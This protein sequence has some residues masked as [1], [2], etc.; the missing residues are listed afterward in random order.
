MTDRFAVVHTSTG[1]SATTQNISSSRIRGENVQWAILIIHGTTTSG[2]IVDHGRISVVFIASQDGVKANAMNVCSA[3]RARH[4]FTS[5]SNLNFGSNATGLIPSTTASASVGR[6]IFDSRITDGIRVEWTEA[7][8]ADYLM[9]VVMGGGHSN[10]F[11]GIDTATTTNTANTDLGFTPDVLFDRVILGTFGN[12]L[13][14][15]NDV[16]PTLGFC[17]ISGLIQSSIYGEWNSPGTPT[18]AD[19]VVSNSFAGGGVAGGLDR[20]WVVTGTNANGYTRQATGANQNYAY[21]AIKLTDSSIAKAIAVED[22]PAGTGATAFT[23]IGIAAEVAVYVANLMTA[24]DTVTDGATAASFAI[25]AF[26][27]DGAAG[28]ATMSLLEGVALGGGTNTT[29]KS[30]GI[31]A[32][33]VLL[34]DAG[35]VASQATLQEIN[36][37]GFVWNFSSATAGRMVILALGSHDARVPVR[38]RVRRARLRRPKLRRPLPF[39][40]GVP[41]SPL[42]FPRWLKP[43]LRMRAQIRARLR[44]KPRRVD[45]VEPLIGAEVIEPLGRV[46]SP[47]LIRGRVSGPGVREPEFDQ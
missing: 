9:T 42:V 3:Q 32:A 35:T 19:A 37:N 12:P 29:A 5:S 1:T 30:D 24:E 25:G 13:T 14:A 38:R 26:G 16:N 43:V 27:R 44:W 36:P 33:F 41:V 2:T 39:I 15:N 8:D 7:P 10:V 20:H 21:L 17:L 18:D 46:S 22:L 34:N 23:G 31:S 6:V 45:T 4:N 47:G 11:A 40:G 28:C